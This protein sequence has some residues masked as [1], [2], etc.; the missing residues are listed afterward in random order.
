MTA[1][2]SGEFAAKAGFEEQGQSLPSFQARQASRPCLTDG[3]E[4]VSGETEGEAPSEELEQP[5]SSQRDS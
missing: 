3:G 5:V 4:T 2:I 1:L